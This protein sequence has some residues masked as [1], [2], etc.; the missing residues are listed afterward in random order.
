MVFMQFIQRLFF[1]KYRNGP[2]AGA[3]N[4]DTV[5]LNASTFHVFFNASDCGCSVILIPVCQSVLGIIRAACQTWPPHRT[6]E[7]ECLAGEFQLD[8]RVT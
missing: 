5:F 3:R 7:H 4:D 2:R 1:E 6:Q 8:L